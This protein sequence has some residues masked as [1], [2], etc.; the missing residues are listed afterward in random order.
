MMLTPGFVWQKIAE[1]LNAKGWGMP[2]EMPTS[3]VYVFRILVV[4][5]L[6]F[7]YAEDPTSVGEVGTQ[8]RDAFDGGHNVEETV[9]LIEWGE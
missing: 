3:S 4:V 7:M 5:A 6:R 2:A 9:G 8:P 1:Y